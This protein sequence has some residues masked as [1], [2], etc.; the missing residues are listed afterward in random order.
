[1]KKFVFAFV[2]TSVSIAGLITGCSKSSNGSAYTMTATVTSPGGS[3]SNFSASGNYDVTASDSSSAVQVFGASMSG[4]TLVSSIALDLFNSYSGPGTY[5]FNDTSTTLA[6]Y[7][8]SGNTI[9]VRHGW[10][11]ISST[12]GEVVKGTFSLT[13]DDSTTITNGVFTAAGKG[14]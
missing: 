1:M 12:S 7:Y 2:L 8:T 11:T 13:L 9:S 3:K 10:V 6:N 5:Y 14:F 4:A